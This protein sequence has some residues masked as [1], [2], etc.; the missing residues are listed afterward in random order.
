[1]I[2]SFAEFETERIWNGERSR[3][4]PHDIQDRALKRLRLLNR[5]ETLEDLRNPPSNRLHALKDDREGQ[6]SISINMQWRICFVWRDG[7]ADD[8]EITDYH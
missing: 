8:V 2:R 1:V 6:H 4:L 7:G 3:K 5:A